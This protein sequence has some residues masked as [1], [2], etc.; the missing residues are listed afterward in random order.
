ML[1]QYLFMPLVNFS[2]C[3]EASCPSCSLLAWGVSRRWRHQRPRG[4]RL[5]L[6]HWDA[7]WIS[8]WWHFDNGH[9]S[10]WLQRRAGYRQ[11]L[12]QVPTT[13]T[14]LSIIGS[15]IETTL[16]WLHVHSVSQRRRETTC[17][18]PILHHHRR[19][20]SPPSSQLSSQQYVTMQRRLGEVTSTSSCL[21][22]TDLVRSTHFMCF[23]H[24]FRYCSTAS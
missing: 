8:L 13:T 12:T 10:H 5:S 6:H 17:W 19:P 20:S 23:L 24:Y 22:R 15:Y 4:R 21:T 18:S 7:P 3:P 9:G 11:L 16:T 2:N 1:P 14:F